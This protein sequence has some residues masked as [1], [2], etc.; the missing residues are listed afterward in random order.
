MSNMRN[1]PTFSLNL[2]VKTSEQLLDLAKLVSRAEKGLI[3]DE[4]MGDMFLQIVRGKKVNAGNLKAYRQQEKRYQDSRT[5]NVLTDE[6]VNAGFQGATEDTLEKI[7]KFEFENESIQKID[8]HYW[9]GWFLEE[10]ERL[11]FEKGQDIWRLTELCLVGDKLAT[12]KLRHVIDE[13]GKQ[14][15]FMEF[16]SYHPNVV[17]VRK[18][19]GTYDDISCY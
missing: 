14:D 15:D 17:Q 5:V 8:V 7:A 2:E 18:I 6:E 4:L 3:D 11:Y 9:V 13:S 12:V 10:R 1:I 16:Y 19:L